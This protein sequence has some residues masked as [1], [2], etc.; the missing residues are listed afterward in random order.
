VTLHREAER[1]IIAKLE[2]DLIKTV[3]PVVGKQKRHSGKRFM[4]T[5][6]GE[7]E[8][9]LIAAAVLVGHAEGR[10]KNPSGISR[11]LGIPRPTVQRKL[12]ILCERNIVAREDGNRYIIIDR[13]P[14]EDDG[15]IDVALRLIRDAARKSFAEEK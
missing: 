9:L 12:Q 14:G 11:W 6:A 7:V 5:I 10:A 2:I 3:H 13:E 1:N 15:Y 8:M 4:T